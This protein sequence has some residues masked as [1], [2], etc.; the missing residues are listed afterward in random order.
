M[1]DRLRWKSGE[2]IVL[3]E[4]W[5]GKVWSARSVTV[6]QTKRE[7]VALYLAEGTR[8]KQP[9]TLDSQ[10]VTPRTRLKREWTL[11]DRT[12]SLGSNLL[13]IYEGAHY[14]IQ[15]MW[16]PGRAL[17]Q[18]WYV[19]LQDPFRFTS[20]GF[21]YMDWLL[22]IVI[23]PDLSKWHWKDE[24]EFQEAQALGLISGERARELRAEGEYVIELMK[25]RKPP[26]NQGWESWRP[27][28]AWPVPDLPEGW[29][30][31]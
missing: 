19:N 5:H 9:K 6:V 31:A 16:S 13:L 2:Q 26:F 1:T 24:G 3:R 12:Y 27:D 4:V 8:W 14:S 15:L 21:D 7:W 29:D 11:R 28:P 25:A 17:F 18:G 20:I 22:D 23:S 30:Y 10:P